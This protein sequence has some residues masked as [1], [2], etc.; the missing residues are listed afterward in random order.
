MPTPAVPLEKLTPMLRQYVETKAERPD[1]I[2]LMRVGDFYEA[3]GDDAE[4]IAGLLNITLTG[5]EVAGLDTKYPMSGVPHHALERYLARL[6]KRG[7]KVAVCEQ[8]EDPKHAKGLV[9]R[10]VTRVVTPGTLVEDSL[11]DAKTNN[12]CVAAVWGEPV[13]GVSVAD[14]STGEFLVTEIPASAGIEKLAEEIGR[15]C[16]AECLVPEGMDDLVAAIRATCPATITRMAKRDLP[17]DARVALMEH[18][19]TTTLRGFGCDEYSSGLDA[20]S[21]LLVY[22]KATHGGAVGHI[23]TMATYSTGDAMV[24][25]AAARRNLE[26]TA[27]LADGSKGKSLLTVLD[28]TQTAM[29]GRLL[30]KWLDAPL[31]SVERIHHRLDRVEAFAL[32]PLVRGDVR[33][34]LR[35]VSDLERLMARLCTGTA[36]ARDLVALRVSLEKIPDIAAHTMQLEMPA[37]RALATELDGLPELVALIARAITDEPPLSLREGGLI[38]D[39]YDE[40]LDELQAIKRGGKG[41]IAELETAERDATGIKSLKI[42]YTSV[43]GYFIEV[44]KPN[45]PNVPAHYIR[46][47]TTSTGE[48]YITPDLKEMEAKVLGA[49]EKIVAREYELFIA[50]V[51]HIADNYAPHV[52]RTAGA[53][54]QLDLVAAL[55]E[56]AQAN[57]YVRPVVDDG[58]AIEIRGGRHPVVEKLTGAATV[59]IPNDTL[60][61]AGAN[62]VHIITGP[63]SAGKST[64]L[65]Q[66]ALIVLLAQVGAFVPADY[67]RVGI[68]D[69]IFTRVGAHDDLAAGQSTFMVEMTETAEILNNATERSLVILDEIGRGT[70]T[71]DGVSIAWAVAEYLA[72]LGAKTLFATHYHLLNDLDKHHDNVQNFRVAVKENAD[73]IVFLRKIVAGGTDKSYGVQVARMAGLPPEVVARATEILAGLEKEG[74]QKRD[75]TPGA[76]E[77]RV[78]VKQAKLQMTLFEAEANPIVDAIRAAD[79]SVLSPIEALNLLYALQREATAK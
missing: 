76:N 72:G 79:L 49:E 26:L 60:L 67:A 69:R 77:G 8:V 5:R 54:A 6:V 12:Y 24:L 7:Y 17:R 51:G 32:D 40:M 20:A 3:Y 1:V 59:F 2:L 70:S 75:M 48:R 11:L 43:F 19:G 22:L 30:K 55:G 10:R 47:Q 42:G 52:L 74:K 78:S 13:C 46:K 58:A 9:K 28:A 34:A 62:Q 61:D 65:R 37:I 35:G 18:F 57:R 27:G 44:T 21:A 63:N 71:Y 68:T 16:P 38:R 53:V 50:L 25:D 64:V 36:N 15:L 14:V 33:D 39:G 41:W 56:V 45:L 29:G 31:L 23:R 66:V 4:L 73:R